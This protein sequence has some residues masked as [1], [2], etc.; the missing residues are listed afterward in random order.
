LQQVAQTRPAVLQRFHFVANLLRVN[1]HNAPR[2]TRFCPCG[3]KN[4]CR[5]ARPIHIWQRGWH[6]LTRGLN[7]ASANSPAI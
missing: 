5:P 4:D 3:R 1:P 2:R 7:N 6:P